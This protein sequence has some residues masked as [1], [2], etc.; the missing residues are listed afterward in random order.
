MSTGTAFASI[1]DFKLTTG[2]AVA[3]RFRDGV[4][5]AVDNININNTGNIKVSNYADAKVGGTNAVGVFVYDGTSFF[6]I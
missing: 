4:R 2:V 3:L 5:Y 1:P 6:F